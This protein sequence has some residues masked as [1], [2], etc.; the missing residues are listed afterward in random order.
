LA[1]RG[2][3]GNQIETLL[4]LHS[5]PSQR[6]NAK[7]FKYGVT[8]GGFFPGW[9]FAG[10]GATF[11]YFLG[12][13]ARKIWS[14]V[15]P[16]KSRRDVVYQKSRQD[17]GFWY[18][19]EIIFAAFVKT[20][21]DLTRPVKTNYLARLLPSRRDFSEFDGTFWCLARLFG[22]WRETHTFKKNSGPKNPTGLDTSKGRGVEMHLKLWQ[23]WTRQ[24]GWRK[25]LGCLWEKGFGALGGLENDAK[26][27]EKG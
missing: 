3:S 10:N 25:K 18:R 14:K 24:K 16:R 8:P 1:P 9:P 26:G 12:S 7:W 27:R 23:V 13:L 6:F 5:I 21:R 15:S 19:R 2:V 11:R 17:C 20:W 4:C 22:F